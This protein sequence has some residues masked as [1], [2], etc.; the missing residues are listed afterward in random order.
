MGF[1]TRGQCWAYIL[2]NEVGVLD[3]LDSIYTVYDCAMTTED[4]T[5]G[6]TLC[7]IDTHVTPIESEAKKKQTG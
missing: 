1:L 5:S 4:T 2:V 7:V 3:L 6:R